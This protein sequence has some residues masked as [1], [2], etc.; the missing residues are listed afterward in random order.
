MN[1]QK[2]LICYDAPLLGAVG[3][4]FVFLVIDG[5]H[6]F[7]NT[8]ELCSDW[9]SEFQDFR[10]IECR[11]CFDKINEVKLIWNKR[12]QILVNGCVLADI[13]FFNCII[14]ECHLVLID[15]LLVS[16][17]RLNEFCLARI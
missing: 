4:V 14:I 15:T 9:D 1:S 16:T 13:E 6:N 10:F 12:L 7:K 11:F 2:S 3:F 8:P 5:Y 17:V